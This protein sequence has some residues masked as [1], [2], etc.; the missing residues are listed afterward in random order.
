MAKNTELRDVNAHLLHLNQIYFITSP[1]SI[2]LN[3]VLNKDHPAGSEDDGFEEP[4][5]L[6]IISTAAMQSLL[7]L[8][9][10]CGVNNLLLTI[11]S[12]WSFPL[13]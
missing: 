2:T 12:M 7:F 1:D 10:T 6:T 8:I 9:V 3:E 11:H 13:R 4:S 5:T